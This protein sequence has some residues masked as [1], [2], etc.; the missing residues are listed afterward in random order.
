[1]LLAPSVLQ[2]APIL[3]SASGAS[4]S[5]SGNSSGSAE[6][7][8]TGDSMD[9]E[10]MGDRVNAL[11]E[12][13]RKPTTFHEVAEELGGGRQVVAQAFYALL[14]LEADRKILTRQEEHNGVI[15]IRRCERF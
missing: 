7:S 5:G 14:Q 13:G 3:E 1:M 10:R 8:I 2:E 9:P 12:Y 6:L 4:G 11:T 15:S